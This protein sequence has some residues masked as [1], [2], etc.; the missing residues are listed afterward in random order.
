MTEPLAP[1]L[2]ELN[3]A[4]RLLKEAQRK[5]PRPDIEMA[6]ATLEVARDDLM[7]RKAH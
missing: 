4:I 1:S 6:I 7:G 2:A 5:S 3:E